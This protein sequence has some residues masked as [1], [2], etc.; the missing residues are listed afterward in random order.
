M[1]CSTRRRRPETINLAIAVARI[2]GQVVL[3][4]IPSETELHVDMHTAMAKELNIQTIRRSNHNAHARARPDGIRA[5][6][7]SHCHASAAA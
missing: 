4:G 6:R 3:I 5:H 1:S 2:G 7:R